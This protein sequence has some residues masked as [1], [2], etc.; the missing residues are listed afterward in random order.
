MHKESSIPAK[1]SHSLYPMLQLELPAVCRHYQWEANGQQCCAS[2][3]EP[4]R[5]KPSAMATGMLA[6]YGPTWTKQLQAFIGVG[7][8]Q[9]NCLRSPVCLKTWD[10]CLY[11]SYDTCSPNSFRI[12]HMQPAKR[13]NPSCWYK[14]ELEAGNGRGGSAG[15]GKRKPVLGKVRSLGK[16][17]PMPPVRRW[18]D[19]PQPLTLSRFYG[20]SSYSQT[21]IYNIQ[22]IYLERGTETETRIHCID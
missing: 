17:M 4:C 10:L 1:S 6:H 19:A 8:Y 11:S 21:V 22:C 9:K 16:D 5:K 12:S 2:H 7:N 14:E 15:R 3:K 13:T 18:S 20:E